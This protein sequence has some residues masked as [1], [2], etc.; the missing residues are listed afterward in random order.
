MASSTPFPFSLESEFPIKER[1]VFLNHAGVAP[2]PASTQTVITEFARDA[3]EEGPANYPAWIHG[4][5]EAR[6]AAGELVH[7]VPD[8]ICFIH[9]TTHGI[10][11]VANSLRWREGDNVVGFEHEFPAN[12]HPWRNLRERGVELRLVPEGPGFR[13]SLKDLEAAIDSRTRLVAVSWVEYSTG[14]R[15]DLEAIAQLC[16]KKGVLLFVDAIQGLGVLPLDVEALGI[17]F[18]A[19]DGHK[20]LLAPEGCGI[21]YVRPDRIDEMSLSMCGWCGLQ[22]P[23]DYDNYDQPYK[24]NAKRFEEGSHNLMTIHALGSSI[25][26]LLDAGIPQIEERVLE[27]TSY[28]IRKLLEKG[29]EVITPLDERQ[30]AGIVS[31]RWPHGDPAAFVREL[32]EKNILIAARRGFLRISPHFYNDERELDQL[33]ANLP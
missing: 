7:T 21:L 26:L 17:D 33:V 24:P 4:M 8:N 15:N 10:L 14:V 28:L 27:L 22:N 2:I 13:Y 5:S 16:R 25:R 11:V 3:A 19:A 20:W 12:I 32:Q 9:N 23:Q 6:Q 30:R 18:L 29:Y 1:Y 31:V